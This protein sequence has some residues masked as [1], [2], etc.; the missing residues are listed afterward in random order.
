V[1]F[2]EVVARFPGARQIGEGKVTAPCPA[3]EDSTPSL[4]ITRGEAGRT[5]VYCQAHCVTADVLRAVGLAERDLFAADKPAKAEKS[6]IVAAYVYRDADGSPR[7]EICRFVPKDFRPRR[8]GPDGRWIWNLTGV[9]RIPYHLPEILAAPAGTPIYIVEG[10]KD[11]DAL[12]ALRL[13][14]TTNPGGC[15]ST[16]LWD[17]RSF[18]DP[19]R[20]RDAVIIPDGDEPGRKHAAHVAASL[21]KVAKSVK[22]VRL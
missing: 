10:E 22:V 9:E 12:A 1:T 11:V 6:R 18:Q 17:T 19:F 8:R 21:A 15:G 4:S 7:Y 2:D 14:A 5:L 16:K 20:G 3:H 13:V